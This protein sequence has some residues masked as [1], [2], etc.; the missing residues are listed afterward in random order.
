VRLLLMGPPG[1]G[2]GTQGER[3]AHR[4]GAEHIVAGDLLRAEVERGTAIGKEVAD[5]LARG[6]LAPDSTV[7]DIIFPRVE[8]AARAGG[9]VL[10]GFP[11]T[12]HQALVARHL[13]EEGG[14][15]LDAAVYLDVPRAE[16]VARILRRAQEEGRADDTEEIIHNRLDV[17]DEAT[18]PLADLYRARGLLHVVDANRPEDKVTAD[19][20]ARL[21]R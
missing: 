19:I 14:F 8:A 9:F 17:F 18:R 5:Y 3:L 11:R 16:L 4:L 13:A 6:D 15:Q 7:I 1:S 20:L 21:G 10:D 2:K 12:V